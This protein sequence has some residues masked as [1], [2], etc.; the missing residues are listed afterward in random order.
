MTLPEPNPLQAS[1][2]GPED[3]LIVSVPV[4]WTT[5]RMVEY[6]RSFPKWLNERVVIVQHLEINGRG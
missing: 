6:R 4:D 3:V 5:E 2:L 1:I